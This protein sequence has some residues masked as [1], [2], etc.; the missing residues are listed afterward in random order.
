MSV[1]AI[2]YKEKGETVV[3]EELQYVEVIAVTDK[4]GNDDE[5]VTVKPDGEEETELPET[6]TLLV[7]PEQANILAEL[8]AQGEIH[9]A[10]VYRGTAENAQKFVDAQEKFLEELKAEKDDEKENNSKPEEPKSPSESEITEN[11]SS[12]E[13]S[14]ENNSESDKVIIDLENTPENNSDNSDINLETEV[15]SNGKSV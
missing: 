2:D 7:T 12:E 10:L 15:I 9:V 4:K 5:T 8:E 1:I 6:V 3:P 13:H 14:D 11:N